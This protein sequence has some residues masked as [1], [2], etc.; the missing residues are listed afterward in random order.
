MTPLEQFDS[1]IAKKPSWLT[2]NGNSVNLRNIEPWRRLV[3]SA[4]ITWLKAVVGD[5]TISVD[6]RKYV[7]RTCISN[8]LSR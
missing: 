3:E 5:R 7:A 2:V 4:G 6:H 8:G 1:I